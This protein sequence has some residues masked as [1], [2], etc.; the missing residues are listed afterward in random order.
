MI[1]NIG[2]TPRVSCSK[3]RVGIFRYRGFTLVELM[4]VS[5]IVA[6][7]AAIA[8]PAYQESVRKT[9]RADAQGMMMELVQRMESFYAQNRC[10]SNADDLTTTGICD[11]AAVAVPTALAQSPKDGATKYYNLSLTNL[12]ATT[13]TVNAAPIAGSAQTNDKC[14][15]LTLNQDRG[16]GVSGAHAGITADD[17]W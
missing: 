1:S 10:Y 3:Q 11:G 2:D 15:T 12:A 14:G 7:L 5:L 6:V 8:L 16:K 13:F 4:I 9:R 17:C